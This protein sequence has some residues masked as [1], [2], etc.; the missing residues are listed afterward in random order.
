MKYKMPDIK[1]LVFTADLAELPPMQRK[2]VKL[3]RFIIAMARDVSEG[4]LTLW[5]MSLV[6]TS[7]LS[8]VPLLAVSF[9]LL[10][11]FGVDNKLKIIVTD[12]LA[13]LGPDGIEL[14][15]RIFSFVEN[16]KAGVLGT[17]GIVVLLYTVVS[18]IQKIEIAINNIWQVHQ[19]RSL[20][21]RFSSYLTMVIVGPL[22][23]VAA[24]GLTATSANH[25]I[26]IWLESIEPF[27]TLIYLG[28]R[29]LPIFLIVL[30]FSFIYLFIPNTKV[31][32][33]AAFSGGLV[34]GIAWQ[35]SSFFFTSFVAGSNSYTAIYSG[36]A[37]LLLSMIWLYLNWL[38]LLVGAKVSYYV[39]H[40][41]SLKFQIEEAVLEPFQKLHLSLSVLY[42]VAT[43][44]DQRE[45][46]FTRDDLQ[47][48]LGC[49]AD[50]L[51]MVVD[52]LVAQKILSI[53]DQF[54]VT[55]LP[56]FSPERI[57]LVELIDLIGGKV[58]KT[59]GTAYQPVDETL[60]EIRLAISQSLGNKTL[61]DLTRKPK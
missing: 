43:H 17:V 55:Y 29:L 7:L 11:G 39:Q 1:S 15:H 59:R 51:V 10:K 31:N 32:A 49:E 50:H 9:S 52:Q 5:A 35:L 56:T 27:G 16:A 20:L 48:K 18:M 23:M 14:S 42:L 13:P 46:G 47:K 40:P 54:P 36:F 57:S 26:I 60:D 19:G 8:L 6:Y 4:K 12:F 25:E 3:S 45:Q 34:A 2:L 41:E 61:Q 44:F 28:S 37:I 58:S 38:I 22:V 24:M 33:K 21:Q 30:I 53:T